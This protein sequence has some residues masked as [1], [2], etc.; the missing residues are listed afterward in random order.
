MVV[1]EHLCLVELS[2]GALG[3]K[4]PCNPHSPD[5]SPF[6]TDAALDNPV[7]VSLIRADLT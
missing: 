6:K 2:M 3:C 1:G 4:T 5:K 7:L